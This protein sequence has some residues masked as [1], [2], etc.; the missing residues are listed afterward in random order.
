M[1]HIYEVPRF[2]ETFTIMQRIKVDSVALIL[3]I[4][5]EATLTKVLDECEAPIPIW[6]FQVGVI[7]GKNIKF[8]IMY[9]L[10]KENLL[11]N[12]CFG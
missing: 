6:Q 2:F 5:Q 9:C 7:H 3:A 12:S 1:V 11:S 4:V 10:L 8:K